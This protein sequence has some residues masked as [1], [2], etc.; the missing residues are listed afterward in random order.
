MRCYLCNLETHR[1][2]KLCPRCNGL[3]GHYK[4]AYGIDIFDVEIMRLKQRN[5]C[6]ICRKE[7]V[8][9]PDR[10]LHVVDHDHTTGNVRELLCNDCNVR[11]GKVYEDARRF[12]EA[13]S[14]IKKWRGTR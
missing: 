2:N 14:Y 8:R 11:L 4:R 7:F 1:N 9:G 6:A 12:P 5:K 10:W 3:N 13:E